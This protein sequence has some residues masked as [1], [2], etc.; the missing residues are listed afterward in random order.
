M[1]VCLFVCFRDSENRYT[2]SCVN[3]VKTDWNKGVQAWT[4][5]RDKTHQQVTTTDEPFQLQL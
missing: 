2:V 4:C 5:P 1:F 3:T